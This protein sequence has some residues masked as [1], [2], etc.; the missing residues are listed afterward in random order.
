V[1]KVDD[2]LYGPVVYG[3]TVFKGEKVPG[4]VKWLGR[5]T[6]YDNDDVYRR[7]LGLTRDDMKQLSSG[8]VI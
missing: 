3:A 6:G 7:L 8:G 5:P 4:R 2:P 1:S